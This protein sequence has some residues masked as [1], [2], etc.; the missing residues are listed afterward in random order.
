MIIGVDL[1]GT[2][3]KLGLVKKGRIIKKLKLKTGGNEGKQRVI[4]NIIKGISLI[5]EGYKIKGIGIGVPGPSDYKKGIIIKTPNLPFKNINLKKILKNKFKVKVELDNDA[6]CAALAEKE[7]GKGK[8][9]E[10]FIILTF[11]TGIG[12]GAMLNNELYHGNLFAPEIGHMII[13]IGKERC[14]INHKSCLESLVSCRVISNEAERVFGKWMDAMDVVEMCDKGDKKARKMIDNVCKYF[15]IGLANIV[16]IFDPELIII[17]KGRKGKNRYFLNKLNQ[18][19]K[20]NAMFRF[21][22]EF[23]DLEDAGILGAAALVK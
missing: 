13:N 9:L 10:N 22:I 21:K 23:S 17:N 5:K 15:G 11:G 18:E 7:Y 8:K 4:N 3:I 6:N 16:N 1:G 14:N 12:S 2:Y 20:K 19:T